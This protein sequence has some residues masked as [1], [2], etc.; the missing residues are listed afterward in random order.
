MAEVRYLENFIKSLR[1]AL[2]ENIENRFDD[3]LDENDTADLAF[4]IVSLIIE[5]VGVEALFA[6]IPKDWTYQEEFGGKHPTKLAFV[7]WWLW[8]ELFGR[9]SWSK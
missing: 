9:I 6:R 4:G 3:K 8:D 2:F 7:F 1:T 5:L